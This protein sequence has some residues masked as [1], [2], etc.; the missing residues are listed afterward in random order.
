[1]N[2][3][4]RTLLLLVRYSDRNAAIRSATVAQLSRRIVAPAVNN[5]EHFRSAAGVKR[6]D[7]ETFE[8]KPS[9]NERWRNSVRRRSVT[10]L[11][12]LIHSPAIS[13][14]IRVDSARVIAARGN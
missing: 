4:F 5:A 2:R 1:M 12:E 14:S 8:A 6:S 9:G 7:A 3:A 13:V 11:T 10:K